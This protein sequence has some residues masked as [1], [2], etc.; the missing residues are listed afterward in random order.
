MSFFCNT[1]SHQKSLDHYRHLIIYKVAANLRSEASRNY[2]SY[3]WWVFEPLMQMMVYY[4]VFGLMLLQ[5][6]DNFVAFLLTGLIPYLWL[7]RSVTHSMMSIVHNKGLMVQVHLPKIILPTIAIC[8]DAVK[9]LV[10]M[11][12]LL[13]FLMLY[14][15][16]PTACWTGLPVLII[17]QLCLITACS[18]VAA[19]VVPFLPDL[20]FFIQIGLQMVMW[21]SGVFYRIDTLPERYQWLLYK[22]NPMA[23]LLHNYREILLYNHWPDFQGLFYIAGGSLIIVFVSSMLVRKFDHVY[24]RVVL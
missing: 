8:Q 20:S 21:C 9:Q 12:L 19:A 3:L 18:F 14:G 24:P 1:M 10:V 6:T 5:G 11:L 15:I 16:S 2:L 17:T 13:L 7:N 22:F 23:N 4:F